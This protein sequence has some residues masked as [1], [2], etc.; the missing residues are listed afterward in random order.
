MFTAVFWLPSLPRAGGG[1]GGAAVSNSGAGRGG[2]VVQSATV[3]PGVEGQLCSQQQW[4]RA[5]RASCAFSNSGAGRGGRALEP[6]HSTTCKHSHFQLPSSTWWAA[7]GSTACSINN[8]YTSV[9]PVLTQ[10]IGAEACEK[11]M[12]E[13]GG[14]REGGG[15][16][17]GETGR[18]GG[19]RVTERGMRRGAKK[20]GGGGGGGQ[21]GK[22]RKGNVCN[23]YKMLEIHPVFNGFR[24]QGDRVTERERDYCWPDVSAEALIIIIH[25]KKKAKRGRKDGCEGGL[26]GVHFVF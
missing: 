3:G 14:E 7:G 17:G 12:K 5:W 13:R 15:D 11:R 4:G 1:G 25:L 26:A 16:E 6:L 10:L 8:V 22:G 23:S 18:E 20:G 9:L 2:P 24:R 19:W 21:R